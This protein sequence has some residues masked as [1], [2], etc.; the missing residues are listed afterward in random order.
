MTGP[1]ISRWIISSSCSQP[2]DD[3]RLEVEAGP[4]GLRAAGDDLR[5]LG[6]ALEKA[7]DAL[8]LA[9]RVDRAERRVGRERVAD[10]EALRLLGQPGDD[11]VV[12]LRAGEHARGRGAVLA[13]VVV[14]GAGD[15][16]Q[17]ALA[18]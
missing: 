7:L 15:R 10:H 6:A 4:L 13:G 11:V 16:L 14:A 5:A 12:D 8:A 9:R 1:K 17:R 3:G 2:G 18:G